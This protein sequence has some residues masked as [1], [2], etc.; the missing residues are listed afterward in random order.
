M[1]ID[2]HYCQIEEMPKD[3]VEF[4]SNELV[5]LTDKMLTIDPSDR[6]SVQ[7]ILQTPLLKNVANRCVLGHGPH[8]LY[9][10]VAR[11]LTLEYGTPTRPDSL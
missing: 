11:F 8:F 9:S 2:D 4:Y 5:E 10:V 7:D 1:V 6:P 3:T